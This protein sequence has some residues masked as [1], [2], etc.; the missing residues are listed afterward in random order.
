[1]VTAFPIQR[2]LDRL[3]ERIVDVLP[4]D[5]AGV[6]LISPTTD[7]RYLA[8][9]NLDALQFEK[10]QSEI[11]E[12]PCLLAFESGHAISI[13][14]LRLDERFPSF[15]PAA[16]SAGL[17]AVFTF[18]LNHGDHPLGALDL[19]RATAGPL[20]EESLTIAQTLADVA[21]AY[22]LNA[23]AREE[24]IDAAARF[25]D[26]SLHDALTG[27]PNRVLMMDRLEHAFLRSRRSGKVSAV[28]FLDLDKFKSV[29]DLYGHRAGDELLVAVARR[30][31]SLLRPEDTL[32]RLSGDEFV[33]LCEGLDNAAQAT[34][35]GHRLDVGLEKPFDIAGHV[36]QIT[37]S[38]G[39]ALADHTRHDP[40]Q[41]LR[42]ADTAM[43][44]AKNGGGAQ[45]KVFDPNRQHEV[46]LERDLRGAIARSELRTVYQP[47]VATRTGQIT[48]FEALLRWDH[49]VYGLV[50]P[51]VA[52]PLAE[53]S[54]LIVEIGRWVVEQA[55]E[56]LNR[57]H[58]MLA[59]D[60]VTVSVNVSPT[61]LMSARFGETIASIVGSASGARALTLEVTEPTF[62]NDGA[63][64]SLILS[65][66]RELGVS[67]ALDDFG[68]GYS[69]LSYLREFPLDIL[70]VDRGLV[71]SLGNDPTSGFII[72]AV[73]QLGHSLG[74][75]VVAEGVETAEQRRH[76]SSLGCDSCQGYY[77]ARP[78]S[79]EAVEQLIDQRRRGKVPRLPHPRTDRVS[80]PAR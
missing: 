75:G 26:A 58:H 40:E 49:P 67:V 59:S 9:S 73:V 43:Y 20:S 44:E 80:A 17:V 14:D 37:T 10:L 70:K 71:A 47:I 13:P 34:A 5:G 30:L 57:W 22:L 1:M 65:D 66:L 3:V 64:A 62:V 41:V 55:W 31:T 79:A 38:V 8:A 56:A 15:G 69:S 46:D 60:D 35:L 54:D 68:T 51:T 4:I 6:S 45:L 36:L 18:P 12:G 33:I 76:V 28:F 2:I 21:A 61:Q 23:Q 77:F 11:G 19:Y 39:V 32:A 53:R 52:I 42:Y 29:N 48:G 63:R 7:P 50:P 78:M 24:L 16:V 72:S 27:L 74:M 25:R